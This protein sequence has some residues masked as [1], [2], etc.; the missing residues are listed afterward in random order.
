VNIDPFFEN[1]L[2]RRIFNPQSANCSDPLGDKQRDGSL[3]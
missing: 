1:H 2:G 3:R